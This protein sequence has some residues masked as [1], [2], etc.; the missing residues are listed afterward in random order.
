[1]FSPRQSFAKSRE[2]GFALLI[3]ITLLAFLVLLLVSLAA[4][5]RVETQVA[6]NNQQL[7]QAR[8]NALLALNIALGQLQ[9]HAGPDRRVTARADLTEGVAN[10]Y[11]TGVWDAS[12]SSPSASSPLAW[13]VSGNETAPAAVAPSTALPDPSTGN[14]SVWMLRDSVE[15]AARVKVRKQAVTAGGVPGFAATDTPVVGHYAYW[16]ADEGLKA[17]A[18]LDDPW[19]TTTASATERSWSFVTA[20]RNG[21]EGVSATGGDADTGD[22]LGP[23]YPATDTDF[24]ATLPRLVSLAQ[25]PLAGTDADARSGLA[26]AIRN[27]PHDLTMHSQSVLADVAQGGLK[28]DLTAWLA[29][30]ASPA[31]PPLDTDFIAGSANYLPRWGL[32]RSYAGTVA[33]GTPKAPVRQ[34]TAPAAAQAQGIH[35]IITY[36]RMGFN[37]SCGWD[38]AKPEVNQPLGFHLFPVVVLWNPSSVP[39]AGHDYELRFDYLDGYFTIIVGKESE[40]ASGTQSLHRRAT[41]S[42]YLEGE[43]EGR[44]SSKAFA[45]AYLAYSAIK[46][47]DEQRP[48][49]KEPLRFL[50][51]S[52]QI[53]PGQ[54]L[55]F[56]LD[57]TADYQAG[58]T[59]LQPH[60]PP[61]T[62][63]SALLYGPMMTAADLRQEGVDLNGDGQ[64]DPVLYYMGN[65]SGQLDISLRDHADNTIIYHHI[66]APSST[67]F[68]GSSP[69]ATAF[70][71]DGRDPGLQIAPLIYNRTELYFSQGDHATYGFTPRWIALLN[72]RA[73]D[74]VRLGGSTLGSSSLS[75]YFDI[76]GITNAGPT[77][78]SGN[79]ASVGPGAD[80]SVSAGGAATDLVLQEFLPA[81]VPLFSLAQLQHANLSLMSLNP[82]YAAGNSLANP[83]IPRDRTMIPLT[84]AGG[85]S[86]NSRPQRAPFNNLVEIHDLSH[87]LNQAL[88]DRYYFSTVPASLTT[89]ELTAAD[90]RLPNARHAFHWRRGPVA[91]DGEEFDELKT[92]EGAAAHLLVNGG[93]NVNSTSV[94][95]WR[96]LLYSRNRL[97]TDPDDPSTYRHPFSRYADAG[98]G[99]SNTEVWRGYRVLSDAQID[100]LAE[101]IVDEVR[102][103]GPFVSLAD[104][105]N[106]RLRDDATGLKGALQAAIDAADADA[107][108]PAAE[109]PNPQAF[110]TAGDNRIVPARIPSTVI[111]AH[112]IGDDDAIGLEKPH[113]SRSVFAPGYLTQADLLTSLGPV[114]AARSDTFTVRAYGDV[115][116]PA[117]E[118]ID[119]IAWCEAVVQ[120]LP[121]Y[122]DDTVAAWTEPAGGSINETFGRRFRIVSFRW[123]ASGDI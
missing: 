12:S 55:V 107:S 74:S 28:R 33:D 95:A 35:P 68:F 44:L 4:L 1:M 115:Q 29:A 71:M 10:P 117:T 39:I 77:F 94:Q 75:Y 121:D 112:W 60:S 116:N 61:R 72:P 6:A 104:F 22:K 27:R 120:R 13:L 105:V 37:V 108:I 57:T 11:Y 36:A 53:E 24:K 2:R 101:K 16:V 70:S 111:S 73:P 14:D 18:N 3:T 21:I 64:D 122:M 7:S 79:R 23:R 30:P 119:G 110:F 5:T 69:V 9:K 56:T 82:A 25:L 92:P 54:S 17:R 114:L 100:H 47:K 43:T 32:I 90:Y 102:T 81:G 113:A 66:Q 62:D 103:R 58:V 86:A 65:S 46:A 48:A 98:A 52:P 59:R 78:G 42:K 85:A 40:A 45:T 67:A 41:L 49:A 51:K 88:W 31:N 83:Y 106:R 38:P 123:L 34:D 89:A 87:V 76:Q 15:P 99:V 63:N 109:R 8:Q 91:N 118:V 96:A 50:L 84:T 93:F 19:N 80:V 20:Q 26:S 97:A